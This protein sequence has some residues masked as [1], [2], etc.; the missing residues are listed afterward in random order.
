MNFCSDN[1]AGVSPEILAALSEANQGSASSYGADAITGRVRRRFAEVFEHEVTV[2]PV[3]SGTA[4]NALALA[5]LVPPWGVVYCH[6]Q[7]HVATHECGALEFYSGGARINGIAAPDGK[8]GAAQLGEILPDGKG[9]VYAMQPSAVSLTQTTEA[10][11]VY[12]CE[13]IAAISAVARAHGLA[14]HMDGARFANAVAHLGV[15]PAEL[16]WKAGVDALSFGA[17]KNGAMGAEALIFFDEKRAADCAFRH[18]RG[19]HLM[20]KTRF[21]SAQLEAYLTDDLWLRNARH[22]NAMARRLAEGLAGAPGIRLRHRVEANEVFA[23]IPEVTIVRLQAKGFQFHR[24]TGNC[25]R[26]VTAFNTKATEVDAIVGA[27]HEVA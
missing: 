25:V 22:A 8:I 23:E 12:R 4:A 7:S 14:L 1:V 2:F 21:I 16:T 17:T 6:E 20:S 26:L 27:A 11:T 10:G 9:L 19:G 5:S 24:W 3:I 13:E 18:M 15:A